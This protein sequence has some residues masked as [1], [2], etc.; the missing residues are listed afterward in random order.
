MGSRVCSFSVLSFFLLS[1][2]AIADNGDLHD[3][4]PSSPV[5]TDKAPRVVDRTEAELGQLTDHFETRCF[6]CHAGR[7]TKVVPYKTLDNGKMV[8]REKVEVNFKELD[9]WL[10]KM[11]PYLQSR[12]RLPGEQK[13]GKTILSHADKIR[14]LTMLHRMRER[15]EEGERA[16]IKPVMRYLTHTTNITP[17]MID[18]YLLLNAP[19]P[20]IELEHRVNSIYAEG[21]PPEFTPIAKAIAVVAELYGVTPEE[22]ALWKKNASPNRFNEEDLER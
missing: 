20:K 5:V 6:S 13:N 10:S 9:E 7:P 19:F 12:T 22:L 3:N 8:E 14:F 15:L 2:V 17:E 11:L 1:M 16:V 21:K 18:A 4:L